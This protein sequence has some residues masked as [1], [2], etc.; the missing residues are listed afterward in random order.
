[1][2]AGFALPGYKSKSPHS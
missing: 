1:M 2:E